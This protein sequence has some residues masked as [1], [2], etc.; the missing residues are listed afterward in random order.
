MHGKVNRKRFSLQR[1][2]T[3]KINRETE[4]KQCPTMRSGRDQTTLFNNN[5]LLYAY[6]STY[7][8]SVG[9][10]NVSSLVYQVGGVGSFTVWYNFGKIKL[11]QETCNCLSP[12]IPH[13]NYEHSVK[14]SPKAFLC[15]RQLKK[16][17]YHTKEQVR[18]VPRR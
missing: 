11:M 12:Y 8:L 18:S 1:D 16:H 4:L 3:Y 17:N 7:V 14:L 2:D 13:H 6:C 9:T 5:A 10:Y 15:F